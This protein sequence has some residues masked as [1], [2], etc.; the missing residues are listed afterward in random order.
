[1]NDLLGFLPAGLLVMTGFGVH[2][3]PLI[4]LTGVTAAATLI[5]TS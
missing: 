5:G 2:T 3:V 4:V 1:M